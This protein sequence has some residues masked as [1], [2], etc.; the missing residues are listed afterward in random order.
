[1]MLGK[2]LWLTER[3][4][5]KLFTVWHCWQRGRTC[6]YELLGIV[7]PCW[8]RRQTSVYNVRQ[9]LFGI[10]SPDWPKGGPVTMMLDNV[11]KEGQDYVLDHS[12]LASYHLVRHQGYSCH[13][14]WK[15][16][17][18]LLF[19]DFN[20]QFT[21]RIVC[22]SRRAAERLANWETWMIW[23]GCRGPQL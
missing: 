13:P 14:W 23:G 20:L 9:S 4:D 2:S 7:S 17:L 10:V 3:M 5:L 12:H 11:R 15:R 6:D 19:P 21:L 18:W 1:M 8:Q 16:W 22:E